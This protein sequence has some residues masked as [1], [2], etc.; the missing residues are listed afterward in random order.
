MWQNEVVLQTNL[1][2]IKMSK[3]LSYIV[4][5]SMQRVCIATKPL[6]RASVLINVHHQNFVTVEHV[7]PTLNSVAG[8]P[9][10][11]SF[12]NIFKSELRQQAVGYCVGNHEML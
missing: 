2:A 9:N 11:L 12:S 4:A 8:F 10:C 7:E 1:L 5:I 3:L 6:S